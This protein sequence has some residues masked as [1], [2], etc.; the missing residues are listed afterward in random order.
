[1]IP[2]PIFIQYNGIKSRKSEPTI[3]AIEST[4]RK[5]NPAPK[6]T[7]YVFLYFKANAKV[8]SCVLS[9]NSA[10]KTSTKVDNN[11]VSNIY[12][13]NSLFNKC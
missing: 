7:E 10:I 5:P 9:P 4:I 12:V 3:T 13:R 8:Q 6:I 11:D 1:M 2:A